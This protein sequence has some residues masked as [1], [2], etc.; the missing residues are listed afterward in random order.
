MRRSVES[1]TAASTLPSRS[2]LICSS[3]SAFVEEAQVPLRQVIELHRGAALV[4]R[5][6][7]RSKLTPRELRLHVEELVLLVSALLADVGRVER[8]DPRRAP[9]VEDHVELR[10]DRR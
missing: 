2:C 7:G 3:T 5:E 6:L 10:D 1:T 8:P 9:E 4:A